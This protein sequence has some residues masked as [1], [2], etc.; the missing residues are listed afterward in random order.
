MCRHKGTLQFIYVQ[1]YFADGISPAVHIREVQ[2]VRHSTKMGLRGLVALNQMMFCVLR[3]YSDGCLLEVYNR[4]SLT[5][6]SKTYIHD[7][8]RPESVNPLDIVRCSDS[9]VFMSNFD[10][11]NHVIRLR[12]MSNNKFSLIAFWEMPSENSGPVGLCFNEED[13]R[14]FVVCTKTNEIHE[15]E[16]RDEK[17]LQLL[18]TIDLTTLSDDVSGPEYC[19]ILPN[20]NLLVS[21]KGLPH[22]VCEVCTTLGA[23]RIVRQYPNGSATYEMNDPRQL[24]TDGQNNIFV[25]DMNN[26]KIVVLNSDLQLQLAVSCTLAEPMLFPQYVFYEA[27]KH[28]IYVGEFRYTNRLIEIQLESLA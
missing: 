20:K 23:S 18:R 21:H 5:F 28:V 24:A 27:S 2:L 15:Y 25:A 14:L 16:T 3:I 7:I 19:L 26:N 8:C 10:E 4:Q 17:N 13:Q 22:G 9:D 1:Y 12:L 11:Q 6:I